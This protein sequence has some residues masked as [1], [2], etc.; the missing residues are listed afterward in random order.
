MKNK[1]NLAVKFFLVGLSLIISSTL[2]SQTYS[3]WQITGKRIQDY[4]DSIWKESSSSSF[5]TIVIDYEM[6]EITFLDSGDKWYNIE[7]I[8]KQPSYFVFSCY[9]E[10]GT[11]GCVI[12]SYPDQVFENKKIFLILH[13][14]YAEELKIERL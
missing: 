2:W 13:A 14:T 12:F 6:L 10:D 7:S 4:K 1:L 3:K 11:E 9:S 5:G 8:S